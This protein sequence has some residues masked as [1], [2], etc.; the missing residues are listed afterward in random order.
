MPPIVYFVTSWNVLIS[1]WAAH[2]SAQNCN[3]SSPAVTRGTIIIA[4]CYEEERS[5]LL[6]GGALCYYCPL[7]H[8]FLFMK[9]PEGHFK[10]L[11]VPESP[12]GGFSSANGHLPSAS[13]LTPTDVTTTMTLLTKVLKH[14]EIDRRPKL[15][16][17]DKLSAI[18]TIWQ[19]DDSQ[20]F[21]QRQGM[22]RRE[23]H[24][25]D[26]WSGECVG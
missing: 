6:R 19:F 25:P 9:I 1:P 22:Q 8:L 2:H 7:P 16:W 4:L 20:I 12:V 21:H 17:L 5:S 18:R 11:K 13:P 14:S 10:V 3:A 26:N 15:T 24:S 23:C